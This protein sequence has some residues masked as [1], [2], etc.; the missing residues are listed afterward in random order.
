MTGVLLSLSRSLLLSF[1]TSRT[2]SFCLIRLNGGHTNSICIWSSRSAG[3]AKHT[4][5]FPMRFSTISSAHF[6]CTLHSLVCCFF[7]FRLPNPLELM[8]LKPKMM[9]TY[10]R[11]EWKHFCCRHF[12]HCFRL[13]IWLVG[14]FLLSVS[15][16]YFQMQNF[17]L[18]SFVRWVFF[19]VFPVYSIWVCFLFVCFF[20]CV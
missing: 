12:F 6:F 19:I 8:K 5:L 4:P 16:F 20:L 13:F 7:F 18:C 17:L 11:K 1:C 9:V 3:L 14:L 10:R 15:N 2:F